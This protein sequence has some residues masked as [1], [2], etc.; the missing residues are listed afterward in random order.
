[1]SG[2]IRSITGDEIDEL[3]FEIDSQYDPDRFVVVE[4]VPFDDHVP[5]VVVF[6]PVGIFDHTS[7]RKR[8]EQ[9]GVRNVSRVFSMLQ[10]A[11]GTRRPSSKIRLS[12]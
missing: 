5:V 6:V 3:A 11:R 4:R 10:V 8:R 9:G 2:V 12:C 7:R 1:M